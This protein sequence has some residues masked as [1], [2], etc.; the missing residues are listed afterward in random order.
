MMPNRKPAIAAFQC[1]LQELHGAYSRDD[2]TE[3]ATREAAVRLAQQRIVHAFPEPV[4]RWP[5]EAIDALAFFMMHARSRGAK[6]EL[7]NRYVE[8]LRRGKVPRR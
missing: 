8:G 6:L 1:A 7:V 5:Q 4:S 3:I 2:A